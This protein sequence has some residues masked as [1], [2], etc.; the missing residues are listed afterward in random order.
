ME[1]EAQGVKQR[2]KLS[3]KIRKVNYKKP[4]SKLY[5]AGREEAVTFRWRRLFKT[6]TMS[7]MLV[8]TRAF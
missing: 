5:L 3:V 6:T 4:P 2:L 8:T 7:S 1:A